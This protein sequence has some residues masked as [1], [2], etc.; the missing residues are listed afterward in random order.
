MRH[1]KS[2]K[3]S[4]N[5]SGLTLVELIVAIIL[6]AIVLALLASMMIGVYGTQDRVSRSS[7]SASEAQVGSDAFR[8]AIR[9][10]TGV[11]LSNVTV[12]GKSGQLLVARSLTKGN[13][14]LWVPKATCYAFLWFPESA[15]NGAIYWSNASSASG[16]PASSSTLGWPDLVPTVTP[17]PLET[18]Q[19]TPA[20]F[21]KSGNKYTMAFTT[22]QGAGPKTTIKVTVMA[23][24]VNEEVVGG[25]Y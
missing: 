13:T 1:L 9:N 7:Q 16:F 14:S 11:K 8:M 19:L 20:V 6:G 10:A 3:Q 17:L 5:D 21:F 24:S 15:E 4:Q 18:G 25:C 2:T 12:S 23:P 22:S